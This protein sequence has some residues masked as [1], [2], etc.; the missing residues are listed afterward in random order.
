VPNVAVG[1]LVTEALGGGVAAAK[2]VAQLAL[3]ALVVL[4]Q[5]A[6][7]LAM[8]TILAVSAVAVTVTLVTVGLE[9]A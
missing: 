8:V 1:W 2:R 9:P 5:A 6:M 3:P 7:M 4:M